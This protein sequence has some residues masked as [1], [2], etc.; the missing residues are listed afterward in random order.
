MPTE[1]SA[2]AQYGITGIVLL[3]FMFRMEKKLDAH[4]SVINDLVKAISLDVLARP[5]A[6]ENIK[7]SAREI[8][9]RADRRQVRA[10]PPG[11]E[12]GSVL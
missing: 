5:G 4:T 1:Y 2:F 9:T 6:H 11:G 7:T 10:H 3:W 8:L 12:N